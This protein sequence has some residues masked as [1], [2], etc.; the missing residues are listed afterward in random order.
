M[1]ED[2]AA[3]KTERDVD[4][5]GLYYKQGAWYLVGHCHLRN[6]ERTFHLA[7]ILDVKPVRLGA[8]HEF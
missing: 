1:A 8:Q 3:R 6:A 4:P 7:R 5:Y 2:A